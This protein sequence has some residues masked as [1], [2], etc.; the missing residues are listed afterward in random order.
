MLILVTGWR[1]HPDQS[2]VHRVL[3]DLFVN[4][5]STMVVVHGAA[6]GADTYADVWCQ[7]NAVKAVRFHAR[8]YGL[9]PQ[10][11]P[12]RN[13]AM[14]EFFKVYPDQDKR[15]LAFPQPDWETAKV[16]G[17]R[18]CI[19]ELREAGFEPLICPAKVA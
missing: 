15:A 3:E 5:T 6:R 19:Q 16:C 12:L 10:C 1:D 7:A 9:W 11:G 13:K 4:R 2:E 17:T 8:N 14:V 18:G